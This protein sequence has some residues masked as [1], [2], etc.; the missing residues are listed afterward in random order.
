M[1]IVLMNFIIIIGIMKISI[2]RNSSYDYEILA[3]CRFHHHHLS[4]GIQDVSSSNLSL[5][6]LV[7]DHLELRETDDLEG[8][9]DQATGVEVN[10]LGAVLAVAHVRSLYAD[11]LDDGL[12]DGRLEVSTSWET[13]ADDGA[14]WANVLGSL[15]EGL[16]VDRDEDD[17]V[18]TKTV[19]S[20]L[21]YIGNE[22]L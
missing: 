6:H 18:R 4:R 3:L 21:L 20:S 8:S 19:G 17:S 7:V 10:G 14:A 5:V 2:Y 13:N 22:V 1:L 11:H 9:L 12:E 15:L 16:L